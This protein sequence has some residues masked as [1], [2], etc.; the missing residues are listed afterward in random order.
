M[1]I[2]DAGPSGR[3]SP[4][5]YETQ[6][7]SIP[8][9]YRYK[10]IA[11]ALLALVVLVVAVIVEIGSS[12]SAKDR[13]AENVAVIALWF[14]I[15]LL[16]F[17][18]YIAYHVRHTHDKALTKAGMIAK[19]QD[20]SAAAAAAHERQVAFDHKWKRR[21]DPIWT[22]VD[23]PIIRYPLG[24]VLV[25]I[26]FLIAADTS[27][28]GGLIVVAIVI[29][30]AVLWLLRELILWVIGL[31]ILA[32]LGS[33]LFGMLAALPISVAIIIGAWIIAGQSRK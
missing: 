11:F 18:F 29:G 12:S 3:V 6:L 31:S 20:E 13:A 24:I 14:L 10:R 7:L 4:G 2:D 25:Y 1:D 23:R 22:S 30:S 15:Y 5:V 19:G 26:G 32:G 27:I 16:P 21:L 9:A 8:A 33:L 17:I 28:T